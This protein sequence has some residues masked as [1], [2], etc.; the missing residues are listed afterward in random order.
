MGLFN[1]IYLKTQKE[2]CQLKGKVIQLDMRLDL[3]LFLQLKTRIMIYIMAL[4]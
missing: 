4:N 1:R 2:I 3:I